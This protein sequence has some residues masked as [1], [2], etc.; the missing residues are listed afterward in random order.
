METLF[1]CRFCG[2]LK[3]YCIFMVLFE[4]WL[5]LSSTRLARVELKSGRALDYLLAN[6]KRRSSVWL[7]E[8]KV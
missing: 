5:L 4:L 3:Q 1:S 6:Q 8:L 7:L 2:I